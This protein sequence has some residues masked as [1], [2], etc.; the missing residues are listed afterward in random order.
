MFRV[1]HSLLHKLS[2]REQ[3]KVVN[4][5]KQQWLFICN[6]LVTSQPGLKTG[7]LL[8]SRPVTEVDSPWR[9][10]HCNMIKKKTL[11]A[12]KTQTDMRVGGNNEA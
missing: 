8:K 12:L 5:G 1:I 4:L 10:K 9:R 3:D 7:S 6:Q 2:K 11:E